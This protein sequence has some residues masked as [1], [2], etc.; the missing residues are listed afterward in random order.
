[1]VVTQM[2]QRLR[3][4]RDDFN[5]DESFSGV[6]DGLIVVDLLHTEPKVLQKYIGR[7]QAAAFFA[8][9]REQQGIL[10]DTHAVS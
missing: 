4:M 6:V 7:E 5:V 8:Y 2:H 1:M 3:R 10:A 9:T